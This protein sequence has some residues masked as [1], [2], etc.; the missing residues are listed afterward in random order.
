MAHKTLNISV[1]ILN[2]NNGDF[3]QKAITSVAV[4]SYP[5]HII[6]VDNGSTDGSVDLLQQMADAGDITLIRHAKNLGF[7]GG[8]NIGIRE[9][10]NRNDDAVALLNSDA[11]ADK[12][13]LKH[14]AERLQS[15]P[16]TGMVASKMLSSDGKKIDSTGDWLTIWGLP[17]PRGRGEKASD[18]YDSDTRVLGASGGA[19]LYRLETLRD[20]G[21]FDN[22][23]FA[24]YEDIDISL[25][26]RLKGWEIYYE[27]KAIVLH[28]ISASS[29]RVKGFTTYQTMKN[30]PWILIKDIPVPIFWRMAPRFIL[31]YGIFFVRAITDGRGLAALKGWLVSLW[32]TPK[33]I[34]ERQRIQRSRA[35]KPTD[36]NVL[37]VHDLPPN[38]QKL[39]ALRGAWW[40][41]LGRKGEPL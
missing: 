1:V 18:T 12:N 31:A 6:V 14:L 15:N 34:G 5:C 38:A 13:W 8:V 30:L 21:L 9:S 3:I 27:P 4:Q 41:L 16:K 35:I 10:I 26:A 19:T 2:W 24:Y 33:K 25:R 17:Y 36:L 29:N 37:L 28:Q 7:A 39:R 23:F 32:L 11:I 22:D 20:I 40:K